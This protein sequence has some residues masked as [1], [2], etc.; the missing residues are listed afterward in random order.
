MSG[1]A[2]PRICFY[3]IADSLEHSN[4]SARAR[5]SDWIKYVEYRPLT[6][7][8][9]FYH[10]SLHSHTLNRVSYRFNSFFFIVLLVLPCCFR[11]LAAARERRAAGHATENGTIS[12]GEKKDQ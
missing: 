6:G 12:S 4:V 5:L 7:R 1:F 10:C 11:A 3:W 8:G 9:L 2:Y